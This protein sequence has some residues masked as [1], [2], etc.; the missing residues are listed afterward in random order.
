MKKNYNKLVR[1]RVPEIIKNSG[2]NC[3]TKIL[4]DEEYQQALRKK[5]IEEATEAATASPEELVKE[6]ADLYEVIDTLI[7]SNGLDE[8]NIRSQQEQR[9]E[10]RGGFQDKIQLIS[11][12]I[13]N[14]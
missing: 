1:D 11:T 4:S 6:L 12:F 10:K 2:N 5:L 3:E 14:S 8:T 7:A 13:N 9:R